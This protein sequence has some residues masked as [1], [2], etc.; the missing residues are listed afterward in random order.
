MRYLSYHQVL[1]PRYFESKDILVEG[2]HW[3]KMM[4]DDDVR[5]HHV[6]FDTLTVNW[7]LE[8]ERFL[9]L[10]ETRVQIVL[11]SKTY[12]TCAQQK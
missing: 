8:G 7:W 6:S 11:A 1:R 9:S 12:R 2:I 4:D 10:C 5:L 3:M